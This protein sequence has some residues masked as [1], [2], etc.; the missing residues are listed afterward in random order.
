M[1]NSTTIKAVLFDVDGTLLDTVPLIVASYQHAFHTCLGHAGDARAILAS[2]GTPLDDF[3]RP[4]EPTVAQALKQAYLEYNRAHLSTD[5][6]IFLKVPALL[7]QIDRMGIP[8]GIVTSKRYEATLQNLVDFNLTGFFKVI[9]TKESTDRHKPDPAPVFEAMRQLSL[10]D[11][12][13]VV[14]VGDSIHDLTS[15]KRAGCLSAIVDW[16]VMPIDELQDAAP[17]LWLK[18]PEQMTDFL[19]TI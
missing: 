14:F 9:I 5:V 15:A 1:I 8:M 19:Y 11:P 18:S 16:T 2:I 7:E 12:K 3:F 13:Q 4:F 6:G 10:E 17:D